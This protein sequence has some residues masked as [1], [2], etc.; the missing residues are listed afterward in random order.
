MVMNTHI[1]VYLVYLVYLLHA[2]MLMSISRKRKDPSEICWWQISVPFLLSVSVTLPER[3]KSVKDKVKRPNKGPPTRSWALEGPLNF[4]LSIL[5]AYIA[6][7]NV[8]VL[9][10]KYLVFSAS[11]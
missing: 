7:I 10:L 2:E 3:P 8:Y 5:S 6:F 1:Y 9:H 11:N 4:K